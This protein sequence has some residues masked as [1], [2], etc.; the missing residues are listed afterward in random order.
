MCVCLSG[1]SFPAGLAGGG[2]SRRPG[3]QSASSRSAGSRCPLLLAP[4]TH[5]YLSALQALPRPFC[6][7]ASHFRSCSSL[8]L[9]LL[10]G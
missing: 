7:K 3:T 2:G 10:G 6:I 4:D 9:W 1:H 5:P 8:F